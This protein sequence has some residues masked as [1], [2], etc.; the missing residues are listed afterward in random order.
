GLT[1]QGTKSKGFDYSND[2]FLFFNQTRMN[3]FSSDS[4]L[5]MIRNT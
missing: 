2:F 3:N 1:I 5:K 4:Q